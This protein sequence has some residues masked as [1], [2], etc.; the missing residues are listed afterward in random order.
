MS[1]FCERKVSSAW[2]NN[3]LLLFQPRQRPRLR[4]VNWGCCR[5]SR[6]VV[7]KTRAGFRGSTRAKWVAYSSHQGSFALISGDGWNGTIRK[8]ER[9]RLC[10]QPLC[11]RAVAV[12]FARQRSAIKASVEECETSISHH[13]SVT[14][15]LPEFWKVI[16]MAK[17]NK[18][19]L[20][21]HL[22]NTT[23]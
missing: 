12:I 2:M 21:D 6:N 13:D 15:R 11:A 23:R 17:N 5:S 7:K 14:V 1:R 19:A 3:H 10:R 4:C 9:A 16:Q 18:M 20:T 22:A 8:H